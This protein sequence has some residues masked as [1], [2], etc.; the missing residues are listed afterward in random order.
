MLKV[1]AEQL[2]EQQKINAQQTSVLELRAREL[3]ES[4]AERKRDTADRRRSRAALAHVTAKFDPGPH[5]RPG[6]GVIAIPC[7]AGVDLT[8]HNT[9]SQPVYVVRVHWVDAGKGSQAGGD[10]APGTLQPDADLAVRRSHSC[11]AARMRATSLLSS[12]SAS[13]RAAGL[14]LGRT[15]RWDAASHSI[16]VS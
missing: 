13:Q 3:S 15:D 9:G 14:G 10:D 8:V 5:L 11:R 6:S 4:I 12:I 7:E 16:F 2:A 1:A